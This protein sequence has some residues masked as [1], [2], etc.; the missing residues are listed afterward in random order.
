MYHRGVPDAEAFKN[1]W[2]P[3]I[4]KLEQKKK[5]WTQTVKKCPTLYN[6]LK[7]NIYI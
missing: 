7:R 6:Y 2:L 4:E 3:M 5:Q 1:E